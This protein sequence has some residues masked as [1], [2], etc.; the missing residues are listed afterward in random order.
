MN[1]YKSRE[2]Y[3]Y[4]TENNTKKG[5]HISIQELYIC[6]NFHSRL[7]LKVYLMFQECHQRAIKYPQCV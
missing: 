3:F 1:S 2:N 6:E 5:L 4:Q 7:S